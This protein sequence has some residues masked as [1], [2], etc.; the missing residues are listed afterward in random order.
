MKKE[1]YAIKTN[2][3]YGLFQKYDTQPNG[4]ACY[5]IVYHQQ[6]TDL[7]NIDVALKGEYFFELIEN[8]DKLPKKKGVATVVDNDE[9]FIQAMKRE[10]I[11]F[12]PRTEYSEVTF[13]GKYKILQNIS[14]PKYTRCL[15]MPTL[16]TWKYTWVIFN[17]YGNQARYDDNHTNM[18]YIVKNPDKILIYKTLPP[19][20]L[21]FPILTVV[22]LPFWVLRKRFNEGYHPKNEN[23]ESIAEE[24]RRY[25]E[26]D[27]IVNEK[28]YSFNGLKE[29]LPTTEWKESMDDDEE[30]LEFCDKVENALK[31]YLETISVDTKDS[32]R[33]GKATMALVKKLNKID[34][35]YGIDTMEREDLCE[36]LENISETLK[37]P[38][39]MTLVNN[40]RE[41]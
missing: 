13:L 26:S 22:G 35:D 24:K 34:A 17:I 39:I 23:D 19:D 28:G 18:K 30:Y 6:I 5:F 32:G 11:Y 20:S 29:T 4:K 38:G 37:F 40:N 31:E 12:K 41:W 15:D 9:E 2:K 7:K 27:S 21:E 14:L 8:S 1:L 3:G 36:Y 10:G 25:F 33:C 16:K